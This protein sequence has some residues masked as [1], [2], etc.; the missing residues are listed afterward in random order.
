MLRPSDD[1][2]HYRH[3]GDDHSSPAAD[4]ADVEAVAGRVQPDPRAA[5]A[6]HPPAARV[7]PARAD[8]TRYALIPAAADAATAAAAAAADSATAD[9]GA[10]VGRVEH[11]A[12][13][14]RGRLLADE[15]QRRQLLPA[16]RQ[17]TGAARR[18]LAAK[19]R[20]HGVARTTRGVLRGVP[21]AGE[22]AKTD[23]GRARQTQPRQE[24]QVREAFDGA[25]GKL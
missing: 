2:H 11:A 20:R 13:R 17:P 16:A 18:H 21:P 14:R 3:G 23:R 19:Q 1:D 22:G 25:F 6:E 10:D 24:D 8:A 5:Q 15:Q 4:A 7:G 12:G 9:A